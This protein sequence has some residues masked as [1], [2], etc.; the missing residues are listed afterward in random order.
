[1]RSYIFVSALAGL[2]AA[3]P[4]PAPQNIDFDAVDSAPPAAVSGPAIADISQPVTYNPSAA[5]SSAA[6][7]ASTDPASQKIKKRRDVEKRTDTTS[8]CSKQPDGYGSKTSPDTDQAFLAN[9]AYTTLS[10]NA[11]VPQ[12]YSQSF[13]NLQGSVQLGSYLGLYTLQK[14]DPIQCQQLCDAA[15]APCY[16]FNLYVERDPSVNPGPGCDD[17]ASITNYKCT[18]YGSSV[19]SASATNTGQYRD[20]FHVVIAASNGYTKLAPPPSYTNFTGP[21]EF[22]GAIN[23]PSGYIGVKYYAG[24]YD[25]SQCAA[26]CQATTA[27]DHR[28][29]NTATGKYDACNFFNSYV[30]SE[31]DVP[32]GTYCSLYTQSWDKSYSTNYGQY[33]GSDYYG[34]SS[35][36]GYTLTVQDPGVIS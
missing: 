33:R 12:G 3:I 2:T 19:T 35:S 20:Q 21:T 10:T 14:Y 11:P 4:S 36:Y 30:L 22:G 13:S 24:P 27:Y 5:A 7:A 17:P 26:A 28:H 18:L 6:L 32:Q 15:S 34:V 31:D 1:M 8:A 25:P 29:Y 16:G 9:P 23:A